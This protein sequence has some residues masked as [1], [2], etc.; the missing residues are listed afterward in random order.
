MRENVNEG[1][2]FNYLVQASDRDAKKLVNTPADL[3]TLWEYLGI[4]PDK[5]GW[6]TV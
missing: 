1:K 5:C 4:K 3:F 2:G 6:I